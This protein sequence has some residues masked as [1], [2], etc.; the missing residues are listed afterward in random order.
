MTAS[1][2]SVMLVGSGNLGRRNVK[3]TYEM[4]VRGEVSEQLI[5]DLGARRSDPLRGKTVIVVDVVD[6]SHLH[7]LLASL[8]DRNIDIERINPV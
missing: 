8:Q 4:V 5:A 1:G 3:T 6:Q 2:Y 7:G